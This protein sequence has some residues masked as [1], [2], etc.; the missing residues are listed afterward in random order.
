MKNV[1]RRKLFNVKLFMRLNIFFFELLEALITLQ[2]SNKN[3]DFVWKQDR[4][5]PNFEALWWYLFLWL[6]LQQTK[7]KRHLRGCEYVLRR[8]CNWNGYM[9]AAKKS[10]FTSLSTFLFSTWVCMYNYSDSCNLLQYK[11]TASAAIFRK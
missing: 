1:N 9:S 10:N 4:P 5:Q 6:W 8:E 2:H 3:G 11:L 7:M